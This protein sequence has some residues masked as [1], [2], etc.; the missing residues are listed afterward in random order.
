MSWAEVGCVLLAA[1]TSSRMG[2][3]KLFFEIDGE[4]VL[5][6]AVRTAAAAGLD[7]VLVVLGHEGDRA[8][9]ELEGLPCLTAIN[10]RYPEGMN[11]SLSAGISALPDGPAAAVVMLADMPFVTA[12]M[13]RVL[14]SRWRGEPLVVSLFGDDERLAAP[15]RH[16]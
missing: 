8:R 2:K 16:E 12:A 13:V 6:R 4:T 11:T 10:P 5:R 15:A 1:G 9:A 14:V 3:N 7:P